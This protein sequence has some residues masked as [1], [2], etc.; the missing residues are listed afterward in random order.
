MAAHAAARAGDLARRVS[1]KRRAVSLRPECRCR[2]LQ[3]WSGTGHARAP[4][5]WLPATHPKAWRRGLLL[6]RRRTGFC[7]AWHLRQ[8]AGTGSSMLLCRRR[9]I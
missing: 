3:P 6:R 7:A 2:S 8:G 5:L 1:C 9:C 4:A